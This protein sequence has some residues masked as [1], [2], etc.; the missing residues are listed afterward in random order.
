MVCF[1]PL[2]RRQYLFRNFTLYIT[3]CYIL[4][5]STYVSQSLA[6]ISDLMCGLSFLPNHHYYR[7]ALYHS[8]MLIIFKF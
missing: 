1:Q 6:G 8:Q 7:S 5:D 3:R 2:K 4:L